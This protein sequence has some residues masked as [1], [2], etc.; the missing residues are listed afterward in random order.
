MLCFHSVFFFFFKEFDHLSQ[1]VCSPHVPTT[2]HFLLPRL[3]KHYFPRVQDISFESLA[4]GKLVA[5]TLRSLCPVL[6]SAVR[7]G[8]GAPLPSFCSL[9][10]LG[11]APAWATAGGLRTGKVGGGAG[12][13]LFPHVQ[14]WPSGIQGVEGETSPSWAVAG[15][16]GEKIPL[17]TH[18]SFSLLAS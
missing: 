17:V 13:H 7:L 4:K 1:R 16:G 10:L 3:F 6:R 18:L 11:P 15:A 14:H 12:L 5:G 9:P 2:H 8:R